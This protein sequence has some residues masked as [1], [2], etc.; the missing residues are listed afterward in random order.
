MASPSAKGAASGCKDGVVGTSHRQLEAVGLIP[1]RL[2][3]G[4]CGRFQGGLGVAAALYFLIL[5][6]G[7][8]GT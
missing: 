4:L 3:V 7:M 5:L 2:K 6:F 1:C 8:D